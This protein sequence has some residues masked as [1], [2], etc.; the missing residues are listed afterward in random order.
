MDSWAGISGDFGADGA[1]DLILLGGTAFKE[2][3][4]RSGVLVIVDTQNKRTAG[5]KQHSGNDAED[6]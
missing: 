6:D 1:E 3:C 2:G 5:L 4:W